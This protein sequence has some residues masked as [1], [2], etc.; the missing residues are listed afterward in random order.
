MDGSNVPG[1][2]RACTRGAPQ[3]PQNFEPESMAAEQC[4]QETLVGAVESIVV[5]K[6]KPRLVCRGKLLSLHSEANLP[7]FSVD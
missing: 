1:P 5:A 4:M 6:S 3:L 2:K 7:I